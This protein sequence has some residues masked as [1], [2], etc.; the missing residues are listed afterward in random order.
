LLESLPGCGQPGILEVGERSLSPPLVLQ[1]LVVLF[2]ELDL[3]LK[4]LN[5]VPDSAVSHLFRSELGS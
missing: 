2:L 4:L 1:K 3:E 5:P